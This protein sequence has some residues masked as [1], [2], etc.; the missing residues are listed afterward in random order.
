MDVVGFV[1]TK[2]L[3]VGPPVGSV[4]LNDLWGWT[5]P[6][7][8]HEYALVGL[9]DG[10]SFVDITN[11]AEPVVLGKLEQPQAASKAVGENS[12]GSNPNNPSCWFKGGTDVFAEKS[13]QSTNLMAS[14]WR[15]L[16]VFNDHVFVVA[17]GQNN[18]GMQVFDLSRLRDVD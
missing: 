7:T 15:D 1:P 13:G 11:P 4:F 12:F 17:D 6:V 14:T 2:D 8:G 18:H 10:V 3:L 16:K 9:V 5:D